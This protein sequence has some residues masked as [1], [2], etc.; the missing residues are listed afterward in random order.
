MSWWE[1]QDI[2][3]SLGVYEVARVIEYDVCLPHWECL[4]ESPVSKGLRHAQLGT[5]PM[6]I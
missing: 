4:R 5:Q 1:S 3:L 6:L 2:Y